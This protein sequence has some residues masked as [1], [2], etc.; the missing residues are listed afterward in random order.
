MAAEL[1]SHSLKAD[2]CLAMS[3]ISLQCQFTADV[4]GYNIVLVI[5]MIAFAL[6]GRVEHQNER[7]KELLRCDFSKFTFFERK[8]L[9][10]GGR[11]SVGQLVDSQSGGMHRRPQIRNLLELGIGKIGQADFILASRKLLSEYYGD[12]GD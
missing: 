5:V 6:C 10:R 2:A 4:Q 11:E 12:N 7:E 8:I 1:S 9:H 3:T